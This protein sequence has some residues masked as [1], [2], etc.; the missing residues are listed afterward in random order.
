MRTLGRTPQSI[1]VIAGIVLADGAARLHR[2][3][4]NAVVHDVQGD[5]VTCSRHRPIDSGRIA[6][7]PIKS[8]IAGS[9]VPDDWLALIERMLGLDRGRQSLVIDF[10]QLG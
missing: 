10:D 2:I 4:D 8:E 9:L 3:N 1:S 7:R 6:D 5:T